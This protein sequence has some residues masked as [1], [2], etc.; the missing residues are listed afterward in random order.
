[1]ESLWMDQDRLRLQSQSEIQQYAK[2]EHLENVEGS[3]FNTQFGVYYQSFENKRMSQK[4]K[5][6]VNHRKYKKDF[7]CIRK[8]IASKLYRLADCIYPVRGTV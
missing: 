2:L 5:N 8:K 3:G 6:S 4:E 1:M 7:W